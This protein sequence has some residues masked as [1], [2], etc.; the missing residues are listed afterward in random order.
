MLLSEGDNKAWTYTDETLYNESA[1]ALNAPLFH[2]SPDVQNIEGRCFDYTLVLDGDTRVTKNS[3]AQL[4]N[5]AAANP[6]RAILQPSIEMIAEDDQSLFMH[7]DKLRQEINAPITAALCTLMGRSGFYGKGL[8]QN[9][10]YIRGVLGTR[11]R[12][13]EKVPIDVLSHDTFEAGALSPLYVN[14]VSLLEEP[15][16]SY[17]TWNIREA[18]WNRGELILSHYFFPQSFGRFFSWSMKTV[19]EKA[20]T[21]LHL[22]YETR[23]DA[24]GA[25][26]AHSALRQ[27]VLKPT[28][29]FYIVSRV[30]VK[31]HFYYPMI[32]LY[33][34]IAIVIVLPK[35][36]LVRRNNWYKVI[37]EMLTC[38]LQYSPEPIV[39]TFRV[40]TAI[41]AHICGTSGWVPQ[42]KVEQ[43]FAI[44]PALIASFSYQWRI[45]V[46]MCLC[47]TPIF[48]CRPE[49]HLLQFLFAVTAFLPMYTTL[50]A[51][52]YS[53]WRRFG[54][55][56]QYIFC[57]NSLQRFKARRH[58]QQR[59]RLRQSLSRR[60]GTARPNSILPQILGGKQRQKPAPKS[61]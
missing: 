23:L 39:G 9:R 21:K 26:I 50:T 2:T 48:L 29:A 1:R 35:I 7:I 60:N 11:E 41:R 12:P 54:K 10:L 28:L 59:Q 33:L 31:V 42:F 15:C 57:C 19:R 32:P 17:V 53:S 36:P 20:P 43:D 61:T 44:K 56:F 18:R 24:A 13:L 45:F 22:R 4:M 34:M 47:L 58:V 8:I 52:P 38:V 6:D 40:C 55:R 5:V 46:F 16:S 27:M 49:D 3:L 51:L 14:S 30:W 37:F 25:Y